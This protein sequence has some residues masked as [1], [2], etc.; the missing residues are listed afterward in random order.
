MLTGKRFIKEISRVIE[1][2][3]PLYNAV[4]R[5]LYT[6][7]KDPEI[8]AKAK[9]PLCHTTCIAPTNHNQYTNTAV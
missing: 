7:H 9:V 2:R 4:L 3:L 8:K 1:A 6:S 5:K